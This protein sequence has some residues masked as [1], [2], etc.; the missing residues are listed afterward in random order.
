MKIKPL[1]KKADGRYDLADVPEKINEIIDL[2]NNS[3]IT[4]DT[5][6]FEVSNSLV[7]INCDRLTPFDNEATALQAIQKTNIFEP[8]GLYDD[9]K[10][11]HCGGKYFKIGAS[12]RTCVYYPPIIKDG[13]NINPDRN[14]TTTE[15]HCL[16]CGKDWIEK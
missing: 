7:P 2:L 12:M 10:C 11:P 3:F 16:E 13:V 9:I 14:T 5:D 8:K 6:I 4:Q 1:I 15:Y